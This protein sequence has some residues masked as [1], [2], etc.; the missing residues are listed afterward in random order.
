MDRK[1]LNWFH[2]SDKVTSR[3][4]MRVLPGYVSKCID[5]VVEQILL[6]QNVLDGMTTSLDN[7]V[8][9]IKA[10]WQAVRDGYPILSDIP[11]LSAKSKIVIVA[12]GPSL[13]DDLDWLRKNQDRIIIFAVHSA[14]VPLRNHGIRPDFQFS[15]DM[16]LNEAVAKAL[17]LHQDVPLVGYYKSSPAMLA[18]VDEALLIAEQNIANPM[19]FDLLLTNTHPSTTTLAFS[20]A[21]LCDPD[22]IY[23]LGVDLGFHDMNG[24]YIKGGIQDKRKIQ[25]DNIYETDAN[26][27]EKG[28]VLTNPFFTNVRLSIEQNIQ[29]NRSGHHVCNLS[30]GAFVAGTSIAKS[31]DVTLLE[32]LEKEG[33]VKAI[34]SAFKAAAKEEN[35]HDYDLSG[36]ELLE[37]FKGTIESLLTLE[38]WDWLEFTFVLDTV[39]QN[40][41]TLCM[42]KSHCLR[43][44]V[45]ERLI[46]DLLAAWY[47]Y[48]LLCADPDTAA[49][50]YDVGR[51][52]FFFILS[53]LEWPIDEGNG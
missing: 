21:C 27:S 29:Q 16:H 26:F 51:K 20:L 23:L 41:M 38:R 47:R 18:S 12:S 4:W 37:L 17:Q 53:Q 11:Q 31:S 44:T 25:T 24:Q 7:E 49:K 6:Q 28:S 46:N 8:Q 50:V 35:W 34:H 9:G 22:E 39:L 19:K 2:S 45:Y 30:D 10:G 13:L 40:T 33:D 48:L 5:P 1:L 15:I 42:Q 3:L 43:M 36:Q 52:R 32:Y 14:V